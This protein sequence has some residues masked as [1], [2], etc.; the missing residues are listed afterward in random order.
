MLSQN[1]G[2][3]LWSFHEIIEEAKTRMKEQMNIV[4]FS[5][6]VCLTFCKPLEPSET[7]RKNRYF[8][9]YFWTASATETLELYRTNLK[10]LRIVATIK[11]KI[12]FQIVSTALLRDVP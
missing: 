3:L 1:F 5:S 12:V 4:S 10:Q 7:T 9:Y 11:L 2:L 8:L 6:T